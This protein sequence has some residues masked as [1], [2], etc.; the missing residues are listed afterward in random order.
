MS[1]VA[2]RPGDLITK[3]PSDVSVIVF[4]WD[5]ENLAANVT[6]ASSAW[7]ITAIRPSQ[8]NTALTK[9][10]PSILAGTRKTQIRVSAGTVGQ[11]YDLTNTIVTSESPAQTKERSV[12]IL[13]EQR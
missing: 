8:S 2:V 9:D 13:V 4:D 5:A 1:T 6:I 12:R 7:A 10:Q 11:S 3:D